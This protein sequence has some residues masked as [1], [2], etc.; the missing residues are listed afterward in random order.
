MTRRFKNYLLVFGISLTM[1]AIIIVA[2]AWL[3]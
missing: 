2:V 1:W 3:W